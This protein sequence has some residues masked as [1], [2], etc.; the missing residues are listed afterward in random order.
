M[1]CLLNYKVTKGGMRLFQ[2]SVL[3]R[4]IVVRLLPIVVRLLLGCLVIVTKVIKIVTFLSD[5]CIF[6]CRHRIIFPLLS[7]VKGAL[8]NDVTIS[9]K[10]KFQE[11]LCT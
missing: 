2:L 9:C 10:C 4:V 6:F 1:Q 5:F 3:F 11:G 8:Q 7:D